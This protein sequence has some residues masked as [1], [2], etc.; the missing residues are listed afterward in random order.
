[1]LDSFYDTNRKDYVRD[2]FYSIDGLSFDR[3]A[4][5]MK[6]IDDSNCKNKICNNYS[7]YT[8]FLVYLKEVLAGMLSL[9]NKQYKRYNVK[10]KEV[11]IEL[12]YFSTD[13][14]KSN[15]YSK[16]DKNNGNYLIQKQ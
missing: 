10:A 5:F 12:S 11:D 6:L 14:Q 13:Y 9:L 16:V 1:M 8:I 15:D 4:A 7:L 2:W 3:F